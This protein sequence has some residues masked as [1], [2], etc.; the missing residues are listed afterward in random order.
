MM[1]MWHLGVNSGK[2]SPQRFVEINC[3]NPA[4]IF[5]M[6]PKKGTISVGADAD[7]VVW[8]PEKTHTLSAATHHMRCDYNLFEGMQV[9]GMP[10]QV[11]LR[12]QKI[13]DGTDF[14]GTNG[15]G[16]YVRRTPHAA[17]L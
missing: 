13:V 8:D 2:I 4:K 12:G 11:Y 7:I 15:G 6:Y 10:V 16:Q 9:K 17:I 14:F 1:V 5:G 3:T